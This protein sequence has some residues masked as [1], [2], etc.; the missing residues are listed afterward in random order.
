V[1]A[2]SLYCHREFMAMTTNLYSTT[3]VG[4]QGLD[5]TSSS[6]SSCCY[7]ISS[8]SFS[9]RSSSLSLFYNLYALHVAI[10]LHFSRLFFFC[11]SCPP[12]P[13]L[14]THNSKNIHKDQKNKTKPKEQRDD[15][16]LK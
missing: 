9:S 5:Y 14:Y 6:C 15:K 13:Q 2:A 12:L 1:K 8:L 16:N 4:L 11:C 3:I 7:S 10:H